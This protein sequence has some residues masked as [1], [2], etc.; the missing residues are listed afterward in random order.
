MLSSFSLT[1][2]DSSGEILNNNCV[3]EYHQTTG[4]LSAHFRNMVSASGG[5]GGASTIRAVGRRWCTA[6]APRGSAHSCFIRV[7][8]QVFA[9]RLTAPKASADNLMDVGLVSLCFLYDLNQGV[10]FLFFPS[11]TDFYNIQ[12]G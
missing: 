4:T 6:A 11:R 9:H 3:M 7:E 5:V 10:T 2:S 12:V 8:K 1:C